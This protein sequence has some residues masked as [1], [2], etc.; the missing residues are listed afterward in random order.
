MV[1]RPATGSDGSTSAAV[2]V[3]TCDRIDLLF[4]VFFA[5]VS[6]S[7]VD[8]SGRDSAGVGISRERCEVD[9]GGSVLVCADG[10]LAVDEFPHVDG[11]M[12]GRACGVG[13]GCFQHFS[14]DV[15][16]RL[17]P[18]VSFVCCRR[19]RVCGIPVG[20]DVA[21]SRVYRAVS[22]SDG[23][24]AWACDSAG[25][26]SRK[27]FSALVGVVSDLFRVGRSED[28]E[29]RPGVAAFHGDGR[30]LP[31]WS[32]ADVDWLVPPAFSALVSCGDGVSY[33]GVGTGACVYGVSAA[34][35]ADR[36]FFYCDALATRRD[37]YGVLH[38][39]ELFGFG[40]GDFPAGRSFFAAV[41]S[42]AVEG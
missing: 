6:D 42:G 37:S 11:G 21:G 40:A 32:A 18:C 12:L 1:V 29:R 20:W 3:L 25:A 24:P 27:Y 41:Y 16:V 33:A 2:A 30:V 19:R 17:F 10:V 4:C 23:I 9:G 15:V 26:D 28:R 31:E 14:A 38:V 35:L 8:R 36:M 5:A 22:G 13:A 34:A 39:S 7:G